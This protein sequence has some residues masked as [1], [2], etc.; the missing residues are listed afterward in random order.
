MANLGSWMA[1]TS[2]GWLVLQLTNSESLLGLVSAAAAA[3][4][5]IL[6]LWA[7]VLADRIDRR[8]LLVSTQLIGAAL[9]A[10]LAA[11]VTMGTVEY[12]QILLIALATGSCIALGNPSF[13]AIVPSLVDRPA[14]GNA[15]ALNSAQFNLARIVGPMTAGVVI[16][17]GGM[18]FGF[19]ANAAAVLLLAAIVWRL[20]VG[21][22][23]SG[24]A[25]EASLWANLADG[26]R[27]VLGTRP[28]STLV[29][30]AA[31]PTLLVLPYIALL[32][33][34]ARDVLGIDAPGLGLLFGAIGMGA[35][36][37]AIGVAVLRP[38][39]SGRLL[40]AGLAAAGVAVAV[41]GVS[42]SLPV[43]LAA[44]AVLGAAQVAYFVTTMTLIQ[45]LSPGRLRGRVMSLYILTSWGVLPIGNVVAGVVAEQAGAAVALVA[46]GVLTLLILGATLVA[47]GEISSITLDAE[48]RV[49]VPALKP[50]SPGAPQG[51]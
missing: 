14:I 23:A 3:P 8:L 18:A 4:I 26:I 9:M 17:L 19:W 37:G 25:A 50:S 33:V 2:Q 47:R 20:P 51:G 46:G 11:L 21:R 5:L 7:G 39:R 6:S 31:V 30:L 49:A 32:P 43:S 42:T 10:V 28:L 40:V 41:F 35:L 38:R 34:Y 24:S 29:L 13:Q 1:S 36:A 44:L 12:W 22:S 16:A 27:Y 15:V 45:A 48:G